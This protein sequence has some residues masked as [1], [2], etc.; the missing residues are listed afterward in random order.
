MQQDKNDIENKLRQLE[1][2]QLPDLS[3][4]DEH[5]QDMNVMLTQTVYTPPKKRYWKKV[6]RRTITYM[7]LAAVVITTSYYA[8]KTAGNKSSIKKNVPVFTVKKT[9]ASQQAKI[10]AQTTTTLKSKPILRKKKNQILTTRIREKSDTVFLKP[11]TTSVKQLIPSVENLYSSLK[12]PPQQF[13]I[14]P[15]RDTILV[16]Q[17]GTTLKIQANSFI[18]PDFKK[19][20]QSVR[21]TLIECYEYADMLAHQLTTTSYDRQLIT[22]GMINLKAE[23]SDKKTLKLIWNRP[24]QLG[25]P[26]KKFDPDMQLFVSDTRQ[27]RL[28]EK[29]D[30]L[31]IGQREIVTNWRPAEQSQAYI[32]TGRFVHPKKI[33]LFDLRQMVKKVNQQTE[34]VFFVKTN[35]DIADDKIKQ[36]ISSKYDVDFNKIKLH[37]VEFFAEETKAKNT[38]VMV[39]KDGFFAN[40]S[41]S[42]NFDRA[43]KEGYLSTKDSLA[44]VMQVKADSLLF[45]EK[46]KADSILFVKQEEFEGRYNFSITGLGWINCDKFFTGTQPRVEF[47]INVGTNME[48]AMSNYNLVFTNIKSVM[49]GRYENGH[50]SFGKLPEGEDVKLVCVLEH[51]N[52]AMACVQSFKISRGIIALLKFEEVTAETFR[53]KIEKP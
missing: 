39:T 48:D 11:E 5:W 46:R 41:I 52:K 43:V 16:G 28:S 37:R 32:N 42:I 3:K 50:V 24:V 12:Q 29:S 30:S 21:I 2:Q 49:K 35:N 1:N 44:F 8:F 38:N 36:L 22:G 20:N 45:V 4:M 10:A 25:M 47:S 14:N 27:E 51:N 26:T 40:D 19:V 6:T 34:P 17:Q 7:G 33:K 23:D 53:Q 15:A 13:E 31:L 18:Y 9:G